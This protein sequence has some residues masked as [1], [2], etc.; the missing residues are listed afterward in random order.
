MTRISLLSSKKSSEQGMTAI[1][2]TMIL[3]FVISL[4]V[5]GFALLS[6]R[7]QRTS[8]DSQLSTQAYYA[9]ESGVNDAAGAI[10]NQ[11]N[12]GGAIAAKTACVD[13]APYKFNA[14][15]ESIL[16]APDGV[17]YTC[18][19]IDPA[20]KTLTFKNV[21]ADGVV[22]PMTSASGNAFNTITITWQPSP[23]QETAPVNCSVPTTQLPTS[24]AWVCKYPMLRMTTVPGNVL[25]RAALMVNARTAFLMPQ[26]AGSGSMSIGAN[27]QV[28]GAHCT[29][30]ECK[31]VIS[32]GGTSNKYFMRLNALYR[33]TSNI[34]ITATDTTGAGVGL[35]GAQAIVDSTGKAQ[36]VLR[37]IVVAVDLTD[38]NANKLPTAALTTGDSVCKRFTVATGVPFNKIGPFAGAGGADNILCN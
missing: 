16:S 3:I 12:T 8:L 23:G 17:S 18:V 10:Q 13:S 30:T 29:V 28:L 7:E 35:V 1:F 36:D 4:L 24:T 27:A 33:Q 2:V 22:I 26:S 9:A 19:L 34:S 15:G 6:R 21:G 31:M 37:R 5:L 32:A 25:S 14:T 38:A 11:L 20:P